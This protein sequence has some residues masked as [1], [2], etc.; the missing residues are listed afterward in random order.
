MYKEHT[1]TTKETH[2]DVVSF[3]TTLDTVMKFRTYRKP[4]NLEWYSS[5]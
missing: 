3:Q 4:D 2:D 5:G 1:H